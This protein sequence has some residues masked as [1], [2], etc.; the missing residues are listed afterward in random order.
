MKS[1]IGLLAVIIFSGLVLSACTNKNMTNNST[2]NGQQNQTESRPSGTPDNKGPGQQMDL[3]AAAEKLGKT[4]EELKAALGVN[5]DTEQKNIAPGAKPS[6]EPKKI[7]LATAAKTLGVTEDDLREALG[8][9]NMPSGQPPEG[10]QKS[11][12]STSTK[13]N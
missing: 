7:D 5:G 6:G 1:K 3:A 11:E 13:N 9:N 12:D 2:N 4:E 8:M 10:E